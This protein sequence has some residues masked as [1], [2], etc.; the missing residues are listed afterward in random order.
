MFVTK[1]SPSVLIGKDAN[2]KVMYRS[3][4]QYFMPFNSMAIGIHD[5]TWQ[6][7]FGGQMYQQGYGSHGCINVSYS[8][9]E[10]LYNMITFDEPVVVYY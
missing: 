10:T 3:T 4:V 7:A 2:G 8:A 5:A 1:E 9:A 6:P